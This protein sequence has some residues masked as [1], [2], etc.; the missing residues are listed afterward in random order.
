[1]EDF[2]FDT[3]QTYLLEK[4]VFDESLNINHQ[5][6]LFFYS[7]YRKYS[8][9]AYKIVDYIYSRNNGEIF[10]DEFIFVN[11]I[12]NSIKSSLFRLY[13]NNESFNK[14]V[15]YYLMFNFM[16]DLFTDITTNTSIY[17][18]SSKRSQNIFQQAI[19]INIRNIYICLS[20]FGYILT[21]SYV[22]NITQLYNAWCK[23]SKYTLAES[24]LKLFYKLKSEYDFITSF[25]VKADYPI[26]VNWIRFYNKLSSNDVLNNINRNAFSDKVLNEIM[27]CNYNAKE[28]YD[29]L[30]LID[31]EL[32]HIFSSHVKND[33]CC[34]DT[35]KQLILNYYSHQGEFKTFIKQHSNKNIRKSICEYIHRII[36]YLYTDEIKTIINDYISEEDYKNIITKIS[37]KYSLENSLFDIMFEYGELAGLLNIEEAFEYNICED[38]IEQFR[39]RI[40]SKFIL[41]PIKKAIINGT[42]K[43]YKINTLFN[44][45]III[46]NKFNKL[47]EYSDLLYRFNENVRKIEWSD[48][49]IGKGEK[50]GLLKI[51]FE[52]EINRFI[53][54]KQNDLNKM[55]N[56]TDISRV[57]VV[58]NKILNSIKSI[59]GTK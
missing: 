50:V 38:V 32:Q 57:L 1:M 29:K 6:I 27:T 46:R 33:N 41:K 30:I 2:T 51:D 36:P 11:Y 34:Y 5:F 9:S 13:T 25:R 35:V 19:L 53:T 3:F 54:A 17:Q 26:V 22:K 49:L 23:S 45:V 58:I 7:Y 24:M 4:S 40:I 55:L 52:N 10:A 31:N 44:R 56:N 20:K 15:K 59:R 37:E 43:D 21:E 14:F 42:H 16:D 8:R 47:M 39:L 12:F 18:I 48:E 28:L